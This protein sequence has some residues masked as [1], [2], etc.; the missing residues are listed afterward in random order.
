MA[1]RQKTIEVHVC[2]A[3]AKEGNVRRC[4]HCSKDVCNDC[5]LEVRCAPFGFLL[6]MRGV[7]CAGPVDE[8]GS[9][10]E[11][12]KRSLEAFGLQQVSNTQ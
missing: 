6:S 3:C 2:D 11:H 10:L 8:A 12:L 4:V 1:V 9:C 5:A 7:V